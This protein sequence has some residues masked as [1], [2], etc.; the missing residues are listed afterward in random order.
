M[1]VKKLVT[2]ALVVLAGLTAIGALADP[3]ADDPEDSP[4]DEP[5]NVSSAF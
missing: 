4:A 1:I 5:T 2:A 3:P